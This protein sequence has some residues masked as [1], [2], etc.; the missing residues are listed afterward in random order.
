MSANDTP[1]PSLTDWDKIAMMTDDEIDYSD[2][3]PLTD[4]F[5]ERA[6]L[7]IPKDQAQQIIRIDPDVL[8][9]F[10]AQSQ[11]Y[12]STINRVLRTHI[13]LQQK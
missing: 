3:P 12:Q 8:D 11:E 1:N 6:K 2:I 4:S 5:F 10:K 7:V 13:E 9:W